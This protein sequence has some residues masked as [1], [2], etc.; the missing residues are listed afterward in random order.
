MQFTREFQL[1]LAGG[2]VS[3]LTTIAV[4]LLISFLFW[5]DRRREGG[6]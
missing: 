2:L 1:V 5:L 6:N 4:L 3:V